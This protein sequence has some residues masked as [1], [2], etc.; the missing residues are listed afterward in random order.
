MARLTEVVPLGFVALMTVL[1]VPACVG[2]RRSSQSSH[3]HSAPLANRSHC[4]LS[5]RF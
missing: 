1:N 3:Q 5:A 4:S 2:D